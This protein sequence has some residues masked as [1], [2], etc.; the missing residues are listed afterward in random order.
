[1]EPLTRDDI[2][3]A[4]SEAMDEKLGEL[5]IDRE[6]HFMDHEFVKG[7]RQ[8]TGT[9]RKASLTAIGIGIVAFSA[10]AFGAWILELVKRGTPS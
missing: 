3:A 7:V 10:W 4:V 8:G 5:Y 9:V 1:M 2:K 6:Q